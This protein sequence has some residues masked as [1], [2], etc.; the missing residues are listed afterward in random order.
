MTYQFPDFNGK[1]VLSAVRSKWNLSHSVPLPKFSLNCPICSHD[2]ILLKHW[3]YFIR[4]NPQSSNPHRCDVYMK[5]TACSA[6][7]QHGIVVPEAMHPGRRK[8]IL[9]R[10]V[11]KELEGKK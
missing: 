11:K 8:V 4:N 9:W 5:C 10:E 6:V 1:S 2:K 3:V 7:W